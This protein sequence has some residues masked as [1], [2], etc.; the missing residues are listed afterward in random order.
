MRRLK[1][2]P[3][4]DMEIFAPRPLKAHP[5]TTR[6]KIGFRPMILLE[7]LRDKSFTAWFIAATI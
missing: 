6:Y 2:G 4:C 7:I 3:F 5:H 1:L